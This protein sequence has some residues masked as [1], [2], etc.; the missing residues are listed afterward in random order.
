MKSPSYFFKNLED[1]SFYQLKD[2]INLNTWDL[3]INKKT[4]ETRKEYLL[5]LIKNLYGYLKTIKPE[6][7]TFGEE[8]EASYEEV[9][10]YE[11][12][13]FNSLKLYTNNI[14]GTIV[15]NNVTINIKSRFGDDFLKYMIASSE[16]FLE[17][18][19]LGSV[20]QKIGIAE[21]L[22]IYYWKIKLKSA[23]RLGL[24]KTYKEKKE[25][26]S[27]IKGKIDFNSL[28]K[29]KLKAKLDCSYRE[30]SYINEI[31]ETIKRA[32]IKVS[33]TKNY[34][35]IIE[36]IT[37]IKRTFFDLSN[38]NISLKNLKNK[39]ILN[40]FY[41]PYQEVYNLSLQILENR[42]FNFSQSSK[43]NALLFDVSLLFEHFIRKLL[44]HN[45]FSIQQKNK[46]ELKIP[47][48]IDYNNAYPDI[49]I[50]H[51]DGSISVYDVKYK[52]FN[53]NEGIK[54][55]D[56][57]Q[58]TSYAALLSSKYKIKEC[59]IIYPIETNN[60]LYQTYKN[61]LSYQSLN[62]CNSKKEIPFR[63]LFYE[64]NKDLKNQKEKDKEFIE[65][66]RHNLT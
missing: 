32:L 47:N 9:F 27:S 64:I 52:R 60:E 63:V 66:I 46:K 2:E 23:F 4:E 48:G 20:N 51:S 25:V 59:G 17:F 1:N 30:H 29:F 49:I 35:E 24:Y 37:P 65:K 21:W 55:E 50:F 61:K 8:F 45:G 44:I 16:G 42:F 18:E 53:F 38:F 14:I 39:K 62:I 26:L 11:G 15:Y 57:F 36:D 12:Y 58:I 19:D 43:F 56:R 34:A 7:I 3:N 54:R 10:S 28:N 22:L 31:N 40:P 41:M 33:K 6:I 13:D 5:E